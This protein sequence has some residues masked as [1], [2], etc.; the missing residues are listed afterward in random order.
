MLTVFF[1]WSAMMEVNA[2]R[3]Y[4]RSAAKVLNY[5]LLFAAMLGACAPATPTTN[6][7]A[8][9]AIAV[10]FCAGLVE[11]CEVP[12]VALDNCIESRVGYA[13]L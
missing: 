10:E 12:S 9:E 11:G 2:R 6:R 4:W 13:M 3:K 1:F 8:V 5:S 7:E